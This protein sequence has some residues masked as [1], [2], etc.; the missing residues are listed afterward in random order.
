MTQGPT[1]LAARRVAQTIQDHF[2]H[3]RDSALQSGEKEL[4]PEPFANTIETM[5]DIAFWASLRH[6]EGH[7]PKISLAFVAPEQTGQPI[8]FEKRLKLTPKILTKLA[9]AVER[10]GIHLGVWFEGEEL[11]VWGA[12]RKIPSLCF[13][14]EVIEPGLLVVKHRR[15]DGFGKFTNVAVLKGE[16][17]KIVNENSARLPGSP[18][19]LQSL[20]S[21]N[22][23][24]LWYDPVNVLVQLAVSM[25]SH[26]RGGTLLV[27]PKNTRAWRDSIIHPISYDIAPGFSG[28]AELMQKEVSEQN[29]NI[30]Q[31]ELR[32]GIEGL[33]GLTGIDGA[34]IITDQYDLL[35]FGAKIRRPEGNAPIEQMILTEPILGNEAVIIHPAQNGG[36]R[37]LSA[38]Q[39]VFDQRDA[40]A[41]VASQD[42]RYTI[43][44]WSPTEGMVH[45]HRVDTLLL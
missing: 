39:F 19:L 15:M 44:G 37:H 17:V 33:A 43:F 7:S 2:I 26:E 1:Y 18:N 45:A 40:L 20:L 36:T 10:P 9:P 31:E 8:L 4:A 22:S 34:T 14:L 21:Y 29:Q 32:R 23:H 16:Q 27:V 30:W 13:V 25:R 28:L 38:A 42:G 5:I 3:H 12:T 41:L 6:E 24:A 11:Y 35:A